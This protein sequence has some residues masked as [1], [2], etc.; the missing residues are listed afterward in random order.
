MIF[1]E[2]EREREGVHVSGM[3][4]RGRDGGR[5][6]E[7]QADSLLSEELDEGL[8]P[9][10]LRSPPKPAQLTDLPRRPSLFILLTENL[11]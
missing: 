1:L 4:G 3:R 6:R 5:G 11:L 2:R 7:S 10:T 9:R 8:H